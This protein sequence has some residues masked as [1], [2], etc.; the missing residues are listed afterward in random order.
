MVRFTYRHSHEEGQGSI[1]QV[2]LAHYPEF[3]KTFDYMG[4]EYLS[5]Q[6]IDMAYE[7][8]MWAG[9]AIDKLEQR[10]VQL[11]RDLSTATI[12]PRKR[13]LVRQLVEMFR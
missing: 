6:Y 12:P 3:V 5:V 2:V 10:V 13:G 1:A 7:E 11:E 4:K 9:L 8:A